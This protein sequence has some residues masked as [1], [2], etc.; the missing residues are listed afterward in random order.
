[1]SAPSQE[2]EIALLQKDVASL[3][4]RLADTVRDIEAL[5][6]ER[7]RALKWGIMTLG[8]AVVAMGYW[9]FN[10]LTGGHLK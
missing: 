1:M 4:Q 3:T 6:D 8:S 2:T 5:Q 9:I 7:N 10:Q